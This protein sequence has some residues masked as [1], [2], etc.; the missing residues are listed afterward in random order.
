MVEVLVAAFIVAVAVPSSMGV[1]SVLA[2]GE[3]RMLAQEDVTRLASA[4]LKEL[5]ATQEYLDSPEGTFEDPTLENRY[6]WTSELEQSGTETLELLTVTVTHSSSGEE[7]SA[8]Q[9][10]FVPPEQIEEQQGG[11]Q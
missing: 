8:S 3:S 9:L 6:S 11:Q 7:A 2:K 5:I 10:L 1:F 4:K